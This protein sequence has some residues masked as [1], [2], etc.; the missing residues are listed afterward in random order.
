M[1]NGGDGSQKCALRGN[2]EAYALI[3]MMVLALVF[4]LLIPYQIEK[5]KLLFGRAFMDM[6][7]TLFPTLAAI[8]M[9][10]LSGIALVQSLRNPLE[11][12]FKGLDRTI[13]IQ[14]SVIIVMLYGFALTFDPLGYWISGILVSLA[15]SLYLGNRNIVTLLVLSLGVP[16]FI[17]FVFTKLLL[18]SLPEGV[19]F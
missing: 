7:P 9:F 14:L 6:K 2:V 1:T 3:G 13:G 19:I 16:S 15:L 11:E 10:V 5:P 17:Y 12:P 4:Y 18:V 8:G